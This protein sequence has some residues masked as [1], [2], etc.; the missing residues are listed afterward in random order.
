MKNLLL[1]IGL[2][3]AFNN[4]SEAQE[5]RLKDL[6]TLKGVRSNPIVGYGLIIG[7]NGTGDGDGEILGDSLK[8]MFKKLG[9]KTTKELSSKNVA[10]VIVTA[11]LPP[12]GGVGQKLD[13]TVSSI[14]K[15]SSLGEGHY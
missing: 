10:A 2:I 1:I 3:F 11:N 7:L 13:V 5:S 4:V 14:G 12:F 15:A 8:N 9:L 6:V